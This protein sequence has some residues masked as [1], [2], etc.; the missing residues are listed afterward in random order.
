M[1]AMVG[2]SVHQ[3]KHGAYQGKTVG[4]PFSRT[5]KI[6]SCWRRILNVVPLK[7]T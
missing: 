1:K 4:S 6:L 3:G 7:T 5:A 2:K